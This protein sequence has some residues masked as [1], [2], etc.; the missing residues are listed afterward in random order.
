M[1]ASRAQ[2]KILTALQ[3]LA[4]AYSALA[5]EMAKFTALLEEI[6][7]AYSEL[8]EDSEEEGD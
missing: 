5:E 3:E 4:A 1:R 7:A 2:A 6:S 8:A